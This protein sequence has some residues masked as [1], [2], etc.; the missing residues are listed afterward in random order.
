MTS[1]IQP[2]PEHSITTETPAERA[3]QAVA[4][5]RAK[6]NE[7]VY[8]ALLTIIADESEKGA[9]RLSLYYCDDRACAFVAIRS[10]APAYIDG[11][12]AVDINIASLVD[13]ELLA[14]R[15]MADGF[16]IEPMDSNTFG[17]VIDIIS[18]E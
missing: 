15:L 4:K 12:C 16:G 14:K 7:D 3:R 2:L 10:N 1:F 13:N 5:Y 11:V 9:V 6:R 8:H 18:W 17:T